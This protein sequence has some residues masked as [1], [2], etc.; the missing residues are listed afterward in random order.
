MQIAIF[1]PQSQYCLIQERAN[2]KKQVQFDLN[3]LC[4]LAIFTLNYSEIILIVNYNWL[5]DKIVVEILELNKS[6]R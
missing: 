3:Q 5:Y 2:V 1:N 6:H 4:D